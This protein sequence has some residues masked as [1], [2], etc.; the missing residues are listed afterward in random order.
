MNYWLGFI[1]FFF[2]IFYKLRYWIIIYI[3]IG[4][5]DIIYRYFSNFDNSL[6]KLLVFEF[7]FV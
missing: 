6:E 3:Y 4:N 7:N 2:K 1:M 5:M